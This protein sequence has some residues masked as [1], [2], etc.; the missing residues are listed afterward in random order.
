M[1]KAIVVANIDIHNTATDDLFMFH[2]SAELVFSC[3][4]AVSDDRPLAAAI[5]LYSYR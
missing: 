1:L 5:K 2:L 3:L 4:P